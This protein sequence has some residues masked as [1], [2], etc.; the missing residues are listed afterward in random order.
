[1]TKKER[2]DKIQEVLEE[3]LNLNWI[4]RMVYDYA[5]KYYHTA[6]IW[7][8]ED[9]R[10]TY[11]YLVDGKHSY[12]A[13]VVVKDEKFNIALNGMKIDVSEHWKELINVKEDV[14]IQTL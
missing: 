12:L 7:D 8:F 5:H 13:R 4:D 1:M 3:S 2:L 11:A 6:D 9:G 10:P 14:D